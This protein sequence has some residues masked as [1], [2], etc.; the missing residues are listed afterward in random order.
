MSSMG[1]LYLVANLLHPGPLAVD[2][3]HHFHSPVAVGRVAVG[4]VR[5]IAPVVVRITH[6]L[7]PCELF[8]L[9]A[10][11]TCRETTYIIKVR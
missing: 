6:K 9:S 1:C 7:V 4:E 3:G 8:G 10:V 2:S 11:T 5:R